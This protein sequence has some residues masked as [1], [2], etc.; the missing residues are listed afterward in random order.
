MVSSESSPG[1]SRCARVGASRTS[2]SMLA[3]AP[4]A[5]RRSSRL[6]SVMKIAIA[7]ASW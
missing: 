3:V 2:D 5:D 1:R 7:A 6:E 4:I